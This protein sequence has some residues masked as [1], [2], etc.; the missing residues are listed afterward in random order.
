MGC[1]GPSWCLR[2]LG[3]QGLREEGAG[4]ERPQRGEERWWQMPVCEER[5]GARVKLGDGLKARTSGAVL[6]SGARGQ[7]VYAILLSFPST[8]NLKNNQAY[9]DVKVKMFSSLVLNLRETGTTV[10]CMPFQP[11]SFADLRTHVP[12]HIPG[13]GADG[14]PIILCVS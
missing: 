6:G 14:D 4:G 10:S 8:K 12:A 2:R 9:R 7:A 5:T 13:D 11:R 3:L 1:L